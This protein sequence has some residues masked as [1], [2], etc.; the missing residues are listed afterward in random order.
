[1]HTALWAERR[2]LQPDFLP[3]LS[4]VAIDAHRVLLDVV[5]DCQNDIDAKR[6]RIFVRLLSHHYHFSDGGDRLRQLYK[7]LLHTAMA[8]APVGGYLTLRTSSPAHCTLRVEIE[9]QSAPRICKR[10]MTES[11]GNAGSQSVNRTLQ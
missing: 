6:L 9:E 11:S 8:G 4:K 3:P 10:P 7:N 5:K 1:M 2:G